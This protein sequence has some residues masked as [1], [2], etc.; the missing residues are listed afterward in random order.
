MHMETTGPRCLILACGNTLRSDDGVGPWLCDWAENHFASDPRIQTISRQQWTPDLAADIASAEAV[1]FIDCSIA[2]APG[3]IL[4]T[5]VAPASSKPGLATHHTGAPELL[6][7]PCSSPSAP[8]PPNSARP[9]AAK[10]PP[11][12]PKRVTCS[13]KRSAA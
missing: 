9:S 11:H 2:S 8:A 6:A 4:L 7:F 1:L 12:S 10:S 3:E 5:E 13:N